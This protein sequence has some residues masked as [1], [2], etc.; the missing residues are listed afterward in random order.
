LFEQIKCIATQRQ[1]PLPESPEYDTIIP[2]LS[3]IASEATAL[4]AQEHHRPAIYMQRH[5]L[6]VRTNRFNRIYKHKEILGDELFQEL[7][8]RINDDIQLSNYIKTLTGTERESAHYCCCDEPLYSHK[9]FASR[10]VQQQAT[11]GPPLRDARSL[12]LVLSLSRWLRGRPHHERLMGNQEPNQTLQSLLMTGV[13]QGKSIF[14]STRFAISEQEKLRP[15]GVP[16]AQ[17]L[18]IANFNDGTIID[19]F[20]IKEGKVVLKAQKV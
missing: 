3:N 14:D 4:F 16:Y 19:G 12:S 11:A 9:P 5:P 6:L 13:Y 20:N 8:K 10:D 18:P 15:L 1:I 17:E 7:Y 2:V